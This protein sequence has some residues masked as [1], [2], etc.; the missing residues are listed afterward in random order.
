MCRL[1]L[2]LW[3][4]CKVTVVISC[5]IC[6][7]S[8]YIKWREPWNVDEWF[9]AAW[10]LILIYIEKWKSTRQDVK[11]ELLS[12]TFQTVTVSVADT[13]WWRQQFLPKARN[14]IYFA[15]VCL[16]KNLVTLTWHFVSTPHVYL[17]MLSTSQ[18]TYRRRNVRSLMR[19]KLERMWNDAVVFWFKALC[20]RLSWGT[21]EKYEWFRSGYSISGS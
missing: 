4:R 15:L 9:T 7:F 5:N 6:A 21:E 16:W 19:K 18:I 13:W 2:S 11:M 10:C 3:F 1:K 8:W 20:L 14:L 17:T 12:D